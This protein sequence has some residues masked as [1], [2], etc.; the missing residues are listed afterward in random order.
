MNTSTTQ[1][2]DSLGSPSGS[3]S[4]LVE[5]SGEVWMV[6]GKPCQSCA[7]EIS[8][9]ALRS[10]GMDET[11]HRIRDTMILA[12]SKKLGVF[13]DAARKSGNK[14][15]RRV[16][17]CGAFWDSKAIKKCPTC[18]SKLGSKQNSD[19]PHQTST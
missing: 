17:C 16:E 18:K 10:I 3:A 6:C 9:I 13:M 8:E 15:V 4:A 14:P 2:P 12:I 1:S 11:D 19:Y 7:R 5:K